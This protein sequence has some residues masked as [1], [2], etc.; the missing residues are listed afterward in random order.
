[1]DDD[2]HTASSSCGVLRNLKMLVKKPEGDS[3]FC[4]FG[5]RLDGSTEINPQVCCEGGN[6]FQIL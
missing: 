1:M 2:T 3:P 5:L 6:V 4:K